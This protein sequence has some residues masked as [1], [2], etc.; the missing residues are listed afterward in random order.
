MFPYQKTLQGERRRRIAQRINGPME[1]W[2]NGK[3]EKRLA[4]HA[5]NVRSCAA[6]RHAS[7]IWK[8]LGI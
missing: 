6:I 2:R 7:F 4:Q 5:D 3:T 8:R 1:E